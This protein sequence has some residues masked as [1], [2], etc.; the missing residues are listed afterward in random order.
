M[1]SDE[2]TV[3]IIRIINVSMSEESKEKTAKI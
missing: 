3:K 2:V 1:N